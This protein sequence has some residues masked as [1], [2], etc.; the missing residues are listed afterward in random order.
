MA[1]KASGMTATK[2]ASTTRVSGR[3]AT[4]ASGRMVGKVGA[5]ATVAEREVLRCSELALGVVPRTTC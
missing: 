1:L 5:R 4:R 3:M 2:E